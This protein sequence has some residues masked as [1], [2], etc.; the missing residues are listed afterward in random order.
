VDRNQ[1]LEALETE[2]KW[3]DDKITDALQRKKTAE[4]DLER[5]Q[6]AF[7]AVL[8]VITRVGL[9]GRSPIPE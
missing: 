6:K 5:D 3:L 9:A 4:E 7:D 2:R 1:Y 8:A